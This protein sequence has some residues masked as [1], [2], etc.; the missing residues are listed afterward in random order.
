MQIPQRRSVFRPHFQRQNFSLTI[1]LAF[2]RFMDS[3]HYLHT[4][5]DSIFDATLNLVV[6]TGK[7]RMQPLTSFHLSKRLRARR[8]ANSISPFVAISRGLTKP[9]ESFRGDI[10]ETLEGLPKEK[11]KAVSSFPLSFHC[12]EM[13]P[14][15]FERTAPGL[16][17]LCSIHLSYGGTSRKSI[18][19]PRAYNTKTTRHSFFGAS[20]T[21]S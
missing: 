14:A 6:V 19:N 5:F 16:G 13:P 11:G 9:R 4:A 8:F 20:E 21:L 15:R 17:I 3:N 1:F 2:Q 12:L 18:T 7:F 10:L